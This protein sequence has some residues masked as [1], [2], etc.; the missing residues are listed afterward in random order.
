MND[1]YVL[2]LYYVENLVK[3][4]EFNDGIGILIYMPSFRVINLKI[5]VLLWLL[6][7][8]VIDI[9]IGAK[10]SVSATIQDTVLNQL[11]SITIHALISTFGFSFQDVKA[12][13]KKKEVQ[14]PTFRA[15]FHSQIEFAREIICIN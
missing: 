7:W 9:E 4:V 14:L 3:H 10:S 11:N 15:T 12:R 6:S 2:M 8:Y 1:T 13:K 5:A